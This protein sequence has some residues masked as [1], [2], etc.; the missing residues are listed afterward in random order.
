M[1]RVR[2]LFLTHVLPYPLDAGPKVRAYYVLRALAQKH[3]VTLLSFTR[4]SDTPAAL[5]HLGEFC[6]KVIT[7]PITREK[8]REPLYFAQSVIHNQPYL[9][10]R[11]LRPRMSAAAREECRANPPDVIHADQLS[12][13]SYALDG[14]AARRT[15]DEHNAVWR[16]VQHM[17][18]TATNPITRQL[19]A[20]EARL[21]KT[22]ERE[23]CQRFDH[24]FT[25]NEADHAA[26]G[27]APQNSSVAPICIDPEMEMVEPAAAPADVV[28]VGNVFY[29]PN[30]DAVMW[31][32]KNV[33][34]R[35][36]SATNLPVRFVIVGAKPAPAIVALA[37]QDSRI[38]VNGY[39]PDLT[40][41]LRGCAAFVA[42]IRAGAGMRV[43]ILDAWARGAPVVST[44]LGA[45]GIEASH[46]DDILIADEPAD[47]A[48]AILHL[49]GSPALRQQLARNA[50]AKVQTRYNWRHRY[51]EIVEK[52][53]GV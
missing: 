8:W 44:A 50:R 35:I 31:F 23:M 6:D 30:V 43:K 20:R 7:V 26:L 47:F 36:T 13:A 48:D 19:F 10:T 2:I 52:I 15:L 4:P 27:L 49:L 38:I 46:G 39:V 17:S 34:S 40:D 33:W 18:E 25:V 5:A 22:Y 9:I 24:V 41:I 51:E 14:A 21:M 53:I 37:A 1:E 45:E 11:D 29:P 12:M 32:A 3:A 28:F 42:P 16:I